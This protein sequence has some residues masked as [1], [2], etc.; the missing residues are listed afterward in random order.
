MDDEFLKTMSQI[1]QIDQVHAALRTMSGILSFYRSEL[2]K[3][4][5][6]PDEAF[7]IVLQWH[8]SLTHAQQNEGKPHG[9]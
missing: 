6:T 7:Q 8:E 9:R 5:F 2:T 4:G 3:K 1:G